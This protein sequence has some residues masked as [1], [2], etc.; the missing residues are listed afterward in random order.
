[1][2]F[3]SSGISDNLS[4]YFNSIYIVIDIQEDYTGTNAK[5]PF[6][7]KDSER[8]VN[9]INKLI[10]EASMKDVVIAFIRQEFD[11]PDTIEF[12]KKYCGGTA[13]KGNP[14]TEFDK[15]IN[16]ISNYCFSKPLPDAFSNAGFEAFLRE[17][18]I[19]EL[20]LVGLD[21]EYCVYETAKGAIKRGYRV[22]IISDGIA[23][24]AENKWD[25]LLKKYEQDGITIIT[26]HEFQKRS[27]LY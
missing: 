25:D 10:V 5:P 3:V 23:M 22:F 1:M 8:L 6:P 18:Q 27:L 11:T 12:S 9:T 26:S 2:Y 21:A 7:Y 16:I 4:N 17:Q 20:Y 15:R 13:I 19:N 14:G 24:Q